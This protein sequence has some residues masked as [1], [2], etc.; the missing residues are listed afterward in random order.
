MASSSRRG[1]LSD[2]RVVEVAS[3]GPGPFAAMMLADLGADVIRL[4]RPEA[5]GV[6]RPAEFILNRGRRS[7]AVNLKHA[8]GAEL[9]LR[10][11]ESAEV[12]IEGFR[13]GVAERLG[14]G[15]EECLRVNPR[16][17]YGR[18]TGWGQHGPYA[19]SPGHDI[20]Y[21]GVTGALKAIGRASG[22]PAPPLNL[23][24]DFGGGGMLL[25]V[26]VLAGVM[27]SR[28]SGLGQVVDAAMVD[29]AALLTSYIVSLVS[30]GSWQDG[31]E[32]NYLDG[33]NPFYDVYLT[34]D[35]EY[36]AV[37]ALEPKYRRALL[38]ELKLVA[39]VPDE[40][41]REDWPRIRALLE[42]AFIGRSREEWAALFGRSDLAL[43]PVH[44]FGDASTNPHSRARGTY[45]EIDGIP[46]PA[47][48]P[49]F[50]R[51]QLPVPEP[52]SLPGSDAVEVLDAW[53]LSPHEIEGLLRAGAVLQVVNEPQ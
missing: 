22:R 27:E 32:R 39:K 23:L 44:S 34:S 13:P 42:E 52:A 17:V 6:G 21:I 12:L 37:G 10:L 47:P 9:V 43:S 46:Q 30:N 28:R 48:A 45:V 29:G 8:E 7:V 4:E 31:L 41:E 5:V 38:E 11:A 33:A 35:G 25:T 24:G 19:M 3:V 15:P 20:N 14:I 53:G 40:P 51:T 49:R 26:G 1:P 2:L 50:S 36:V 16:L 18:A